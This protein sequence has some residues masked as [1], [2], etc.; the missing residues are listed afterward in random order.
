MVR[1]AQRM[2]RQQLRHPDNRRESAVKNVRTTGIDD[3]FRPWRIHVEPPRNR[4][5]A[6]AKRGRNCAWPESDGQPVRIG[7]RFQQPGVKDQLP[8][9]WQEAQTR[10]VN[11]AE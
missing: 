8:D 4:T 2:A 7:A 5:G 11:P 6:F 3:Q 10:A 9:L 1:E